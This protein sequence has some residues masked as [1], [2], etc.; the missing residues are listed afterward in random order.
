[1]SDALLRLLYP[2]QLK[3]KY[4]IRPQRARVGLV[5]VRDTKKVRWVEILPHLLYFVLDIFPKHIFL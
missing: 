2:P 4:Y 3:I 1:M 5:S